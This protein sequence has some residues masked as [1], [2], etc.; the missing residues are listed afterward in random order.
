MFKLTE[1][2]NEYDQ[3]YTK[4]KDNVLKILQDIAK[5]DNVAI[6]LS[7]YYPYFN[8]GDLCEYRGSVYVYSSPS[9][10]ELCD[11]AEH[12]DLESDY[13]CTEEYL[14]VDGKVYVDK[15]YTGE[16]KIKYSELYKLT[17][18]QNIL[19]SITGNNADVIITPD[20][21]QVWET[22]PY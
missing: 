13:H 15:D 20:K 7:G 8:D 10:T 6:V 17:D 5:K 11:L 22:E 2:L 9:L 3:S 19:Q 16:I 14:V 1:L 21:V 4:L 18:Y 12:E